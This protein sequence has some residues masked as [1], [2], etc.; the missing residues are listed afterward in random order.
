MFPL[1]VKDAGMNN[2]I[3]TD[4]MSMQN[5]KS[6]TLNDPQRTAINSVHPIPLSSTEHFSVLQLIVTSLVWSTHSTFINLVSN[7]KALINL[8]YTIYL[9]LATIW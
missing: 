9:M 3:Q 2:F 1:C 6:V 4:Q 7:E 5:V 8:L